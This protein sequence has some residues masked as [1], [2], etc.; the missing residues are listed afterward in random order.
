MR[1]DLTVSGVQIAAFTS[2]KHNDLIFTFA[3]Q[4]G[5]TGVANPYVAGFALL[6]CNGD[7]TFKTPVITTTS[8]SA[9]A[10]T[11]L[12]PPQVVSTADFNGDGEA[13]LLVTVPSFTIATGAT[14]QLELFLSNGDGT[15]KAPVTV[16]NAANPDVN[17]SALVPCAVADFNKDGKLDVACLGETSASQAQLGISLGNGDG[18]FAAPAILNVGGGDAI[19][20]SGIGAA[21]FN[22]DG[23]VDLALLDAEDFSGIFY[24]NGDGTFTSVPSN[25]NSYPK[26]LINLF[27]GGPTIAIDLNGD[28]KPDIL[29]GNV[30]FINSYGTTTVPPPASATATAL[31]ASAAT[32]TAGASVTF[33]ATVTGASGSTGT[34]TGTVTFLDGTTTLGTPWL[35]ERIASLRSMAGIATS[36]PPLLRL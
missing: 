11:T 6:P 21:D 29:A 10:P 35:P 4:V 36:Q 18:T 20:S 34:P 23:K 19:R 5:G 16:S 7:G 24:G 25:G 3:D 32:I 17:G 28:G 13:D 1:I 22:G 15:F 27:A 31:T 33:T 9:T 30:A 8:S 12:I 26:D 2:S 14:S